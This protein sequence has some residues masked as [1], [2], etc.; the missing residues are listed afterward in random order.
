MDF[1]DFC[2]HFFVGYVVGFAGFAGFVGVVVVVV[3]S[4]S[5]VARGTK[6]LSRTHV[7]VYMRARVDV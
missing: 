7:H 2:G 3:S 5:C 6:Q 1:L 4:V